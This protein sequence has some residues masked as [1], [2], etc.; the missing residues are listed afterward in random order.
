M[1]GA[2]PQR[3]PGERISGMV[4]ELLA[5]KGL[6]PVGADQNLRD[7]GLASLDIVNLMLAIED[8]FDLVVPQDRM[9]PEAFRSI[10]AIEALVASLA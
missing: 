1:D 3:A 5:K 6:A 8:S 2:S 9:T 10:A 7:A 4:A